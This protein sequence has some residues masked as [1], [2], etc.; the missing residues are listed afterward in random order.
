ME[1]ILLILFIGWVI[2][3]FSGSKNEPAKPPSPPPVEEEKEVIKYFKR[4]QYF[5]SSYHERVFFE[6]LLKAFAGQPYAVF[7]HVRLADV[8][9]T[10]DYNPKLFG[11]ISPYHL[12]FVVCRLPDY[13]VLFT[14][15]LDSPN[16]NDSRQMSRDLYKTQV[17]ENA[18]LPLLRFRVEE[19]DL[20]PEEIFARCS[21]FLGRTEEELKNS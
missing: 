1:L 12:D 21:P 11:Y 16:H 20:T 19:K 10:V 2:Y 6:K 14:I 9:N 13:Q 8:I 15:E 7:S 3:K 17:L 18:E 4:R 5:F